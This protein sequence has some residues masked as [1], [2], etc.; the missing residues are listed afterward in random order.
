ML[1]LLKNFLKVFKKSDEKMLL[2]KIIK[3]IGTKHD[4]VIYLRAGL[5]EA[6]IFYFMVKEYIKNKGLKN[7]CFIC[8]RAFYNELSKMLAPDIPFYH[9]DIPQNQLYETFKTRN[10]KYRGI[11]F[12][13]NPSTLGEILEVWEKYRAKTEMRHYIDVLKELNSIS[14]LNS[15]LPIIDEE[16]KQSALNK[17]KD[18]NKDNFIFLIPDVNFFHL[19]KPSVWDKIKE[20]L[21]EKGYDLFINSANFSISEAYYIATLSKGIVGMRGGFSEVLSTIDKPKHIIYT[22]NKA[23]V[24]NS[25]DIFTLKNYPLVNKDSIFEY[26]CFEDEQMPVVEKILKNF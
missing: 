19:L 3:I 25:I 6:Y 4:S 9:I 17:I 26:E 22:R 7:P 10:I 14:N 20:G 18:L 11:I 16:T 1:K 12:N 23:R 15:N 2:D 13:V 5:G 24:W 8:H 21:K